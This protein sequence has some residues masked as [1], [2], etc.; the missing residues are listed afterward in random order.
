MKIHTRSKGDT[1]RTLVKFFLLSDP[2]N[3]PLWNVLTKNIKKEY[4]RWRRYKRIKKQDWNGIQSHRPRKAFHV[5]QKDNWFWHP[6]N[7]LTTT[8]HLRPPDDSL[9]TAWRLPDDYLTTA[10]QL[11]DNILTAACTNC[12]YQI[13]YTSL[14]AYQTEYE[15]E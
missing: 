1:R 4:G 6:E 2:T 12:I 14:T 8:W 13:D 5:F 11:F 7:W 10:W 15:T 3:K 9:T